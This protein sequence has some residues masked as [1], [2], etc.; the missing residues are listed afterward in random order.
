MPPV[1]LENCL[2][3]VLEPFP[4]VYW[5]SEA[6]MDTA[7]IVADRLSSAKRPIIQSNR[8]RTR[9]SQDVLGSRQKCQRRATEVLRRGGRVIVDRFACVEASDDLPGRPSSLMCSEQHVAFC[10][11][12][13][14]KHGCCCSVFIQRPIF[15]RSGTFEILSHCVLATLEITLDLVE[16]FGGVSRCSLMRSFGASIQ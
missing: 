6:A 7:L 5:V 8:G 11:G 3:A 4:F 15:A 9:V 13:H 14:A 1:A 16:H 10:T 12:A 2:H